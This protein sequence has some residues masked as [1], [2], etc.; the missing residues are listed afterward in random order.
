MEN[1]ELFHC[2]WVH[3]KGPA[4][5]TVWQHLLFQW[6]RENE[7]IIIR[8]LTGKYRQLSKPK[9]GYNKGEL[10]KKRDNNEDEKLTTV[11]QRTNGGFLDRTRWETGL[12]RSNKPLH[13]PFDSLS[14][15]LRQQPLP[16]KRQRFHASFLQHLLRHSRSH[17]LYAETV[18][19]QFNSFL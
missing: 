6:K 2:I 8:Y 14:V 11:N 12:P 7:H 13:K 1:I 3:E 10:T 18:R 5:L 4:C 16:A 17:F 19:L 15:S 9:V